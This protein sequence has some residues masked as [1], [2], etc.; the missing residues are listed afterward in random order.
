[1]EDGKLENAIVEFTD[2]ADYKNSLQKISDCQAGITE[3]DYNRAMILMGD[4]KYADAIAVFETL[5]GY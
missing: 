1:M 2:I 5:N 3:N 4:G